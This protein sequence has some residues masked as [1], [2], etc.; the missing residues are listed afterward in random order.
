M[1]ELII[2]IDKESKVPIYQQIYEIPRKK[3]IEKERLKPGDRAALVQGAFPGIFLSAEVP[4]SLLM[5]SL[6]QKDTLKLCHVK[7][8][9]SLNWKAFIF[10]IVVYQNVRKKSQLFKR[11]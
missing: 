11:E 8:I 4:Q 1:N 9:M 10:Q 5:I 3:E 7:D 6:L 2:F